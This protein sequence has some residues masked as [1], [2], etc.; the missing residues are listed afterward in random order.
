MSLIQERAAAVA[1]GGTIAYTSNVGANRGLFAI[2]TFGDATTSVVDLTDTIGNNWQLAVRQAAATK[3]VEI[4][5]A[6]SGAGGANTVT[7]DW[8]ATATA[9]VVICEFDGFA[10]GV[11][12]DQTAQGANDTTSPQLAGSVTTTQATSVVLAG[13]RFTTAFTVNS[14]TTGFTAFSTAAINRTAAAWDEVTSTGTY[15]P[16]ATCAADENTVGAVANFYETPAGG[17]THPGW[18]ST[19][20]GWF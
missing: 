5:Y 6:P 3:G 7:G 17:A 9:Q 18:R 16:E 11:S 20:G 1:D 15:A 10:N 8:S 4:W 13:L 14:W 12:V 19:K 2:V